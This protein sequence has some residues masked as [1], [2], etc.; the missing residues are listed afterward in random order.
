MASKQAA[1]R[2]NWVRVI[3][4]IYF[5]ML[6]TWF[7]IYLLFGDG[8]GFLG[9]A[10]AVAV[11]FFLPIPIFFLLGLRRSNRS[12]LISSLLAMGIFALLWGNLFV[13]RTGEVATDSQTL[14]VM[15]FNVLGRAGSHEPILRAIIEEDVDI[16]F[17]QELTPDVASV[18]SLELA[19]LYP[20]QSLEPASRSRGMGIFSKYPL[21]DVDVELPGYWMGG[22]QIQAVEWQGEEVTLV[23]FHTL[24]TGN[25]WP[26]WVRISFQ[27]REA[28]MQALADFSRDQAA[29]GPL[30]VAG[31]ANATRQNDAYK[32]L[33]DVLQD[34][35]QASGFGLGHTFPG[36]YSDANSLAQIS[37]FRLPYW[38]VSI[39]YIFFSQDFESMRSWQGAF[40]GGS[41][42]RA[43]VTELIMRSD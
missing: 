19:K 8:A 20:H 27:R 36:P 35:W 1:R 5:L 7:L 28:D 31:D 12:L 38:L 43:V 16:L 21:S 24:P 29:I 26:R 4:M 2:T 37:I 9:L 32:L 23:N 30:I 10:N 34:A 33:G 15:T 3:G 40:Y 22:P 14:R 25:I 13:G 41:D 39:D 18:L 6:F 11:F 17:V 42:H